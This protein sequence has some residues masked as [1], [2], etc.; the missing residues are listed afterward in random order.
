MNHHPAVHRRYCRALLALGFVLLCPLAVIAQQGA[1]AKELDGLAA[2]QSAFESGDYAKSLRLAEAIV[3]A[4]GQRWEGQVI[5]AASLA[6][7]GKA[8]EAKAAFDKARTVVPADKRPLV[9]A[10]ERQSVA[11]ADSKSSGELDAAA[12]LRWRELRIL[13]KDAQSQSD[14]AAKTKA[15]REFQA[16]LMEF[17]SAHPDFRDAWLA[18]AACALELDDATAGWKSAQAFARLG[19]DKSEDDDVLLV[20]L[21]LKKKGWASATDPVL[22]RIQK[23]AEA[24]SPH[25]QYMLG[26]AYEKGEGVPVDPEKAKFW[27]EKSFYNNIFGNYFIPLSIRDL[28]ANLEV[29]KYE[30]SKTDSSGIWVINYY[31]AEHVYLW[32]EGGVPKDPLKAFRIHNEIYGRIPE[33]KAKFPKDNFTIVKLCYDRAVYQLAGVGL[34]RDPVAA[35]Q[36]LEKSLI[37]SSASDRQHFLRSMLLSRMFRFG[38]GYPKD[39]RKAEDILIGLEQLLKSREDSFNNYLMAILA[40]RGE[41]MP[42]DPALAL[43]LVSKSDL[44]GAEALRKEIVEFMGGEG[45]AAVASAVPNPKQLQDEFD[46]RLAERLNGAWITSPGSFQGVGN[47]EL[48]VLG[49][50]KISISGNNTYTA[51][52][53]RRVVSNTIPK[54]VATYVY[55]QGYVLDIYYEFPISDP[56]GRPAKISL[57]GD[58]VEWSLFFTND[59]GESSWGSVNSFKKQ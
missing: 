28:D 20:Y 45:S 24:G 38:I 32:G 26:M 48:K 9:D 54:Q 51:R 43:R 49:G 39:T 44:S 29:R 19:L 35:A 16:E 33:I 27:Q 6:K 8:A 5:V 23:L 14:P 1:P 4:D 17:A 25:A 15:M 36:L 31:T 47:I 21:K 30:E 57:R 56:Q 7:L 2:A 50:G 55:P 52:N 42:R 41:G 3:S 22:T 40:Y 12:R 59:D 18:A 53:G 46:A 11:Q 34:P 13:G 37:N 10:L 58:E